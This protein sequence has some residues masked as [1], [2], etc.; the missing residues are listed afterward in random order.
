MN[1]NHLDSQTK[2]EL[3]EEVLENANSLG[4]MNFFLQLIEDIKKAKGHPLLNKSNAFHY[5]KGKVSWNKAIY[6]DTLVLLHD[7]IKKSEQDENYFD[8]LK[9]KHQKTTTNMMK[10]LKPIYIQVAP[11]DSNEGEGFELNIIDASNPD[12]IKI[13][14]MYRIIFFYNTDFAKDAM[15]YKSED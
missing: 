2:K 4:G 15:T 6:K 8:E 14:M 1:F 13:S 7:T 12:D 5:S 10:A 11:K 9:P 3:H